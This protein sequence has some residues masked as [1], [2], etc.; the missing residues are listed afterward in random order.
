MSDEDLMQSATSSM[1][2]TA[3]FRRVR[4]LHPVR[5]I[6]E[7][8]TAR[9]RAMLPAPHLGKQIPEFAEIA[10]NPV[11]RSLRDGPVRRPADVDL[12]ELMAQLFHPSPAAD[13][14]VFDLH[15]AGVTPREWVV[16]SWA[17]LYIQ[18]K[19]KLNLVFL[20]F[21]PIVWVVLMTD[22]PFFLWRQVAL[23]ALL[24]F[25]VHS[26]PFIVAFWKLPLYSLWVSSYPPAAILSFAYFVYTVLSPL[27]VSR[28]GVGYLY[29][30]AAI[31]A[32]VTSSLIYYLRRNGP[33]LLNIATAEQEDRI[34][35]ALERFLS[36][37]R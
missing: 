20:V 16:G 4:H 9:F 33:A 7:R 3:R 1:S 8:Y 29:F 21:T 22:Y 11:F 37:N 34:E 26:I 31:T 13:Q 27:L 10:M 24:L 19:S 25:M 5:T 2:L 35:R 6:R 23:L 12:L 28:L 32:V 15:M 36:V 14:R 18:M 17:H 30:A